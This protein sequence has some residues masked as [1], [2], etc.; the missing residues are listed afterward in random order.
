MGYSKFA[1]TPFLALALPA[2]AAYDLN[3]VP[4]GAEPTPLMHGDKIEIAGRELFYAEDTKAGTTRHVMQADV[5]SILCPA[6]E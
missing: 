4:L 6:L 5:R 1:L 2:L 3:G